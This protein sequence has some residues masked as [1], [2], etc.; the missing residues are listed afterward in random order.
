M[1]KW[2]KDF[3]RYPYDQAAKEVAKKFDSAPSG[4][5]EPVWSIVKTFKE[6]GRWKITDQ[7]DPYNLG[8][9]KSYYS[10]SVE[11]TKTGE[12]YT[13]RSTNYIWMNVSWGRWRNNIRFPKGMVS[14]YLPS[15]MT[16]TEKK[17]VCESFEAISN[18]VAGRIELVMDRYNTKDEKKVKINQD[19]ERNRL[20]SLYCGETK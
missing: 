3:L 6:K 9:S 1:T 18:K 13:M 15:W 10:F 17:Y 11:D 12:S 7:T 4:I 2:I 20:M 16:E 19:K 8:F 14:H 5:S